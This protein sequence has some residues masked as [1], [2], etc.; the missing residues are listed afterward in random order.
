LQNMKL[1]QLTT[2]FSCLMLSRYTLIFFNHLI[3]SFFWPFFYISTFGTICLGRK[4]G[5][6]SPTVT[7]LSRDTQKRFAF[8]C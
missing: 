6:S 8:C 4:C 7:I 5:E 2:N 1:E 3:R